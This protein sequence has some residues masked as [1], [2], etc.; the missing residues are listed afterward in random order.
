MIDI[1]DIIVFG[2]FMYI[3]ISEAN[4]PGLVAVRQGILR[5][6]LKGPYRRVA[7]KISTCL[8]NGHPGAVRDGLCRSALA[9]CHIYPTQPRFSRGV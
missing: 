1:Y 5:I 2:H 8:V 4:R 7:T 3:Y 6:V 9:H